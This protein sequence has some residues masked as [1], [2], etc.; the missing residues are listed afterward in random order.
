MKL[1]L[2]KI[3]E[4]FVILGLSIHFLYA[5]KIG[6]VFDV[7]IKDDKVSIVSNKMVYY[8]ASFVSSDGTMSSPVLIDRNDAKLKVNVGDL[9]LTFDG[10][11]PIV[12]YDK[13]ESVFTFHTKETVIDRPVDYL[14]DWENS[15]LL[16]QGG[17]LNSLG[18]YSDKES[19]NRAWWIF[20]LNLSVF[21]Q[22]VADSMGTGETLSKRFPKLISALEKIGELKDLQEELN[23]YYTITLYQAE[24]FSQMAV[25]FQDED[26]ALPEWVVEYSGY[27]KYLKQL[28]ENISHSMEIS[29]NLDN[30]IK[31]KIDENTIPDLYELL[32]EHDEA[33]A[34]KLKANDASV[35][36][37]L[38]AMAKVS[39]GVKDDDAKLAVIFDTILA[40]IHKSVVAYEGIYIKNAATDEEK[41]KRANSMR[42]AKI[43]LASAMFIN[44]AFLS[45]E[46]K[47]DNSY[48]FKFLSEVGGEILGLLK[49]AYIDDPMKLINKYG[50]N[51]LVKKGAATVAKIGKGFEIGYTIGNKL[52]PFLND[53]LLANYQMHANI[54]NAKVELYGALQKRLVIKD[55]NGTV[56][57]EFLTTGDYTVEIPKDSIVT[58]ELYAKQKDIFN[59]D[60]SPWEINSYIPPQNYL[61]GYIFYPGNEVYLRGCVVKSWTRDL[62]FYKDS[63]VSFGQTLFSFKYLIGEDAKDITAQL[64]TKQENFVS[65]TTKYT[66]DTI[67]D[68]YKLLD[69]SQKI[70]TKKFR[71]Q[72]TDDILQANVSSFGGENLIQQFVVRFTFKEDAPADTTPPVITITGDNPVNIKVGDS[73]T[74]AGATAVDDVDGEVNVTTVSNDVDTT[75]IGTY[76]VTYEA[77]DVAGNKATAK[78]EVHVVENTSADTTPPVITITGD[79]PVIIKVGDSYIDAG[80]TAVDDV[81]GEVNVTTVSNDVDTTEI[82]TYY[83]TYEAIDVAGNKATAKREVHVVENNSADTTPPVITITGD[84]PVTLK[85]GDSYIDA[86]A[87]A[88]DDVDGEVSVTT[89]SNDVDTTQVG[90][91]Y[92]TY[93]AIDAAGNKATAT[94]EVKVSEV[95]S[96]ALDNK[97]IVWN[98][99]V[100]SEYVDGKTYSYRYLLS[101]YSDKTCHLIALNLDIDEQNADKEAVNGSDN[102]ITTPDEAL[103]ALTT[104]QWESDDVTLTVI[105]TENDSELTT[106][107]Q[108]SGVNVSDNW[109][110]LCNKNDGCTI[111]NIYDVTTVA[112]N[113]VGSH[114]L[115]TFGEDGNVYSWYFGNDKSMAIYAE[116]NAT[117]Q[118]Q[119]SW[120]VSDSYI[121]ILDSDGSVV[122]RTD[123]IDYKTG[124][125]LDFRYIK[126]YISDIRPL[127]TVPDSAMLDITEAGEK[128]DI[129]LNSVKTIRCSGLLA[130]DT[131][132]ING[133]EYVVVDD[134]TIRDIKDGSNDYEHICTSLVTD[135][136]LLFRGNPDFNQ[137]IGKWDVSAV[138]DMNAMFTGA[139]IF[140]RYIGDWNVSS[141]TNM[142]L[143]FTGAQSF[144]QPLN[145]WNVSSVVN[146]SMMFNYALK[147]N[148]PLNNWDVSSVINIA[149]MF[150]N[151]RSFNQPL[152]NW[153]LSSVKKVAGLFWGATE[154]NQNINQ[155]NTSSVTSMRYVFSDASNFN[156]P[157]DNWDVSSVTDM[158]YMFYGAS[159][160]NQSLNNWDVSSVTDMLAMFTDANSFN[161][162]LDS[163]DVSSVTNMQSMFANANSFNQNINNWDVSSVGNMTMM[164]YKAN[165]FNQPL[166]QWQ[167]ISVS[168]MCCM[169]SEASSFNQN[170]SNWNVSSVN[171][172]GAMFNQASSFSNQDLS[173]WDVRN[174]GSHSN[175]MD[176]AGSGNIEPNWVR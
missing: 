102:T 83:V 147:F 90:T 131:F 171:D 159:N 167:P 22:L 31:S 9:N 116:G 55:E 168:S 142:E 21:P 114:T 151:A 135:M 166:D 95:V 97:V 2:K 74:D 98:D 49:G 99:E 80:A 117:A 110:L 161:Q 100:D 8:F 120:D 124:D 170:I 105:N 126:G 20:A 46:I 56:I 58:V 10:Y 160:F 139:K 3:L 23:F 79:N 87:T 63:D 91:Y 145:N 41:L 136:H 86:G 172:M 85:V 113:S 122:L 17:S 154:F 29:V 169:F 48:I 96:S 94:R 25:S 32:K 50:N 173:S 76:Y 155:W 47:D 67:R 150:H 66:L 82:G 128:I 1:Y 93:E 59:S 13:P 73:Y 78:R 6:E 45:N 106:T 64:C 37:Y 28:I 36:A 108:N 112:K 16:F 70:F 75:Q 143:M 101:L 146:M 61:S 52:I 44:K 43:G 81:D 92:V 65:D 121:D 138:T 19:A 137:D 127:E 119:G 51:T 72:S 162:P 164:F 84:N 132:T 140:N 42:Y 118:F 71:V 34:Q 11:T 54:V 53:F 7:N 141:V 175:F 134:T 62:L 156:Q 111:D 33:E 103:S 27:Y 107:L 35:D 129:D 125:Y 123:N 68:K 133:A 24:I 109:D 158:E 26:V 5:T 89:V 165:S 38:K 60:I 130:G 69:L 12:T 148:Q 4:V 149:E 157:L 88:V 30:G 115:E 57:S 40:G 14:Q 39:S 152:N 163:W 77:T 144:N 176:G 174:V 153:N 18:D 15:T 104:C